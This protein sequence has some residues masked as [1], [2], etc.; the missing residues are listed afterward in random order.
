MPDSSDASVRAMRVLCEEIK[1]AIADGDL[2]DQAVTDLKKAIDE[3][4]TRVWT[5][6]E[7]ARSGDPTWVQE[8]WLHRAAEIC[9]SIV[10]RLE[11]GELD[12]R[13]QRAGD[14]RAAAER[15]ASSLDPG[16][17]AGGAGGQPS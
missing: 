16:H 13:S 2:P 12:P 6:M 15:L 10:Q 17:G 9:R 8:F 1:Q 3:T 14:L 4:R 7:A 5:S 11:R